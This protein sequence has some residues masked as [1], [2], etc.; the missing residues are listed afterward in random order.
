MQASPDSTAPERHGRRSPAPPRPG[1]AGFPVR[2]DARGELASHR[3]GQRLRL[4][5]GTGDVAVPW[6]DGDI[7]TVYRPTWKGSTLVSTTRR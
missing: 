4:P 6:R 7:D 5:Q 3:H 1:G 2:A